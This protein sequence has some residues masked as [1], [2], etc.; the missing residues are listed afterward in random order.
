MGKEPEYAELDEVLHEH[1]L[2]ARLVLTSCRLQGNPMNPMLVLLDYDDVTRMIVTVMSDDSW[3]GSFRAIVAAAASSGICKRALLATDTYA[4]VGQERLSRQVAAQGE[5]AR[6]WAAGE[7]DGI[8]EALILQVID[9]RSHWVIMQPYVVPVEAKDHEAA[10]AITFDDP[11]VASMLGGAAAFDPDSWG[12]PR[13]GEAREEWEGF[14]SAVAIARPG[15]SVAIFAEDV[16]LP[17]PD[18]N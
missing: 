7:R 6:R 1:V 8:T 2:R 5:L 14:G 10:E 17:R 3:Q 13:R 12:F 18:P 15:L 9:N 16:P 11:T 4:L